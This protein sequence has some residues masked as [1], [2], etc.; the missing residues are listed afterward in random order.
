MTRVAAG[1]RWWKR[2]CTLW[3]YCL[4]ACA[5]FTRAEKAEAGALGR[6]MKNTD[7]AAMAD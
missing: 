5:I 3:V 7:K 4:Q 1:A 2:K 6:Q